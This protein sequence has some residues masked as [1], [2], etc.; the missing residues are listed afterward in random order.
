MEDSKDNP[1]RP[2]HLLRRSRKPPRLSPPTPIYTKPRQRRM[3]TLLQPRRPRPQTSLQLHMPHI[4]RIAQPNPIE[5]KVL[6]EVSVGFEDAGFENPTEPVR[7]VPCEGDGEFEFAE[8]GGEG[9][10]LLFEEEVETPIDIFDGGT[11]SLPRRNDLIQTTQK[12][13][14]RAQTWSNQDNSL[15]TLQRIRI[16]SLIP[17]SLLGEQTPIR[18]VKM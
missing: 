3:L 1:P 11:M 8:A 4:H 17:P 12:S 6:G 2:S 14:K 13:S 10:E 5:F 7:I 9:E 18:L 16:L 15:P